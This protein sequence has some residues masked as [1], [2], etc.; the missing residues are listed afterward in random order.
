MTTESPV[1]VK[2]VKTP[3]SAKKHRR[4]LFLS[5]EKTQNQ[6]DENMEP[7]QVKAKLDSSF[8]GLKKFL[9]FFSTLFFQLWK[10]EQS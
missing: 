6:T 8:E 9:N 4:K 10:R 2:A 3:I 7:D 5:S 1:A